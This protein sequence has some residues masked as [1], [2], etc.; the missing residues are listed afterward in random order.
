MTRVIRH[1]GPDGEGFMFVAPDGGAHRVIS[2]ESP[3]GVTGGREVPGGCTLG[4]G[5]R[6]L[7]ILDLSAAGHQPMADATGECWITYNGEIY[8]YRELREELARDGHAFHSGTDTEVILAA[9]RAWGEQ[10]LARFNGMFAFVLFDR[11]TRQVFAARDRF[12]IKPLYL[13]HT[14]GG[15]LALVSEIK[16]CNVH[17]GW[18]ARLNGQRAYD[19]L[20]WGVQDHTAETMFAN[21]LQLRGGEYL[22]STLEDLGVA[23]PQRWYELQAAPFTGDFAAAG[24]RFRELLDDSVRLRLRADVAVGSCLSGGLDSSSIVCTMRALLDGQAGSMQKTFSAYSDTARFDER[25]FIAEVVRAT[26]AESHHVIPS[27]A[28]LLEEI[29]A[30]AWHQDEPFG[31]TSI[32]AQ[33]CVFRLARE[34]NVTVMLDGQGA[35]EAMGGYHSFFGPRLAGLLARGRWGSAWRESRA[36]REFYGTPYGQQLREAANFLLVGRAADHVRAVIRRSRHEPGFLDLARLAAVPQMPGGT[37]LR[38]R[39]PV[40]SLCRAQLLSV[41]LPMLLHWEDRNSMAFGVEARLPFLDYRLVEF[42][43]GLDEEYK[44]R[45][46]WTKRVL[47]EGMR[48]RL[49]EV[50]R[51]RR[52][53]LGFATAEQVWMREKT[54][55][56]IFASGR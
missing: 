16:Q 54:P 8:N 37:M 32:F 4:F 15:G 40:S 34:N 20:N 24:R 31:S 56:G 45:D 43:L 12:G 30:L 27:S 55:R 3:A 41:T 39:D 48:G 49:P 44:L 17:P 9:W 28:A 23:R 13:W 7:S 1:R 38:F 29:D 46:G 25:S 52:D 19:F 33:R 11:R 36:L 2:D 50:V 21:V 53:K 6:R 51:L 14:P 47:R 5:H 22:L 42:C 18:R 35:D 10:C 26:G